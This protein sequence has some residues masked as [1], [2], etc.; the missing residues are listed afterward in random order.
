MP[1]LCDKGV[2]AATELL[3][4]GLSISP[5]SVCLEATNWP[6]TALNPDRSTMLGVSSYEPEYI[7]TCRARLRSQ[8]ASYDGLLAAARGNSKAAAATLESAIQSFDS[9]FYNNMVLTLDSY[10]THRLRTK[11]GK[12]GNPLNEVRV[13]CTSLLGNGGVLVQDKTIKLDPAKSVLG[14]TVGDEIKVGEDGF[15]RLA[16]AYFAAVERTYS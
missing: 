2:R 6:R 5:S 11:E 10:F 13:L 4:V 3:T 16:E 12:D 7:E 9:V 8:I 15:T 14:Y 1:E